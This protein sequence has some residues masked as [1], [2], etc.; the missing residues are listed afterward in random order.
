MAFAIEAAKNTLV[1]LQ[2]N[3]LFKELN[4][5]LKGTEQLRRSHEFRIDPLQ[6]VLG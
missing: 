4:P 1:I 2:V 3:R 5:S 6:H